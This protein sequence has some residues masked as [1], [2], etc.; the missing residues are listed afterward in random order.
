MVHRLWRPSADRYSFIGI[1][2]RLRRRAANL[3]IRA[4]RP[5][6]LSGDRASDDGRTTE[7]KGL[8]EGAWRLGYSPAGLGVGQQAAPCPSAENRPATGV[9]LTR[10]IKAKDGVLRGFCPLAGRKL[11]NDPIASAALDETDS[12]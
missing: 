3:T 7:A 11:A 2:G 4:Q 12:I 8:S 1:D 5:R 6:T 9:S 10:S